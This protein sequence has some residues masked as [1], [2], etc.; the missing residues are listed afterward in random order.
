MKKIGF[1]KLQA[2]ASHKRPILLL[3]P[4]AIYGKSCM[5]V[6][7]CKAIFKITYSRN[8]ATGVSSDPSTA[9]IQTTSRALN[10]RESTQPVLDE[11]GASDQGPENRSTIRQGESVEELGANR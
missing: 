2:A 11:T 8:T 3:S 1:S 4:P 10:G 6:S 7:M 5:F 9:Q